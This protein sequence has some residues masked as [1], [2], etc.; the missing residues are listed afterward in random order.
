VFKAEK[1]KEKKKKK[2]KKHF[3]TFGLR[4]EMYLFVENL[5]ILLSTGM[6]LVLALSIIQKDTTSR[7]M[8]AIVSYVLD[9]IKKGSPFGETMGNARILPRHSL[10]LVKAGEATGRLAE[11]LKVVVLQNDKERMFRSKIRSSLLYSTIVIVLTIVIGVVTAMFTLPKIAS[12][13]DNFEAELPPL[14]VGLIAAGRFLG[15]YGNII[16]PFA[17]VFLV[18]V[19]YFLFSFPK[20]KFIGHSILF[21]VPIIKN[22]IKQAEIARFGFILGT[23]LEA[24]MPM[25]ESLSSMPGTTTFRNYKK[26]YEHMIDGVSKGKMLDEC[27]SGYPKINMLFPSAVRQLIVAAEKSGK[28][29]ETLFRIGEMYEQRVESTAKNLP[30]VLEPLLIV[31][32]GIVIAVLALGI[33]LPIYNL[34]NI[35]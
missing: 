4:S 33:I 24:G 1:I 34:A 32:N 21:R 13:F 17:L 8:K 5:S 31:I 27:F 2:G 23:M 20:T 12:F 28:L 14:T 15:E 6:G 16:V 30:I 22:L 26:F 19:L 18:I 25:R 35:I 11:N 7:R 3:F 29:S 10:S 9:E